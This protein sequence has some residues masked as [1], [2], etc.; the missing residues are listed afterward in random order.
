MKTVL[1]TL[2]GFNYMDKGLALYESLEKVAKDFVLYVLAMDDDCFSFLHESH[3][4]HLIP[5]RLSEFENDDLRAAKANRPFGE[6]CWT[7]TSSLIKYVLD[8]YEEPAC[9][10]ID[11]DLFFYSDPLV[12]FD[13]LERR[14]GSVLLTGHRFNRFESDQENVVGRF[15]VE[16]NLFLNCKEAREVLDIWIGQCLQDC[17]LAGDGIVWGDQKYLDRWPEM[18]PFVIETENRGAGVAPWNISQYQLVSRNPSTGGYQLKIRREVVDLVFYHFQDVNYLDRHTVKINVY[19]YF[20]IDDSI[21]VPLYTDY[22][23]TIE[24]YKQLFFDKTGREVLLKAHPV[25]E[26][27][28]RS[29]AQFIQSAAMKLFSATDWKH[30]FHIAIPEKLFVSKDII[31]I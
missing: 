28:D 20:G 2:F 9:A 17:S 31:K 5:I 29:L 4:E 11:A 25:L 26:K 23:K 10:Y 14:G 15:C 13:E 16:F 30:F 19:H 12:L 8:R 27:K 1:C 22:L 7:C 3:Y 18:Y 24:R 6:Y 21:V